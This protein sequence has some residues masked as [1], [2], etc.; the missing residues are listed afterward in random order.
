MKKNLA[1]LRL[2]N[3]VDVLN[4]ISRELRR[5]GSRSAEELASLIDLLVTAGCR[6]A[7]VVAFVDKLNHEE[8]EENGESWRSAEHFVRKDETGVGFEDQ[9]G[10][11]SGLR[12]LNGNLELY[13]NTVG[14]HG[15]SIDIIGDSE[16]EVVA[17][18]L[19]SERFWFDSDG[20]YLEEGGKAS[21]QVVEDRES[22][23]LKAIAVD[24]Q[25][26]ADRE[27]EAR[28]AQK[29]DFE[30][31]I[32]DRHIDTSRRVAAAKEAKSAIDVVKAKATEA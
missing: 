9:Y 27:A 29:A 6:M 1:E 12:V 20:D 11:C 19:A 21:P 32:T 7:P 2:F 22:H 13:F 26:F 8:N 15:L 24:D 5:L 14:G 18:D 23:F 30:R 17:D 31:R 4:R 16:I 28:L 25:E 3:V 10:A